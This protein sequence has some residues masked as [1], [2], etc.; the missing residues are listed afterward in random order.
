MPTTTDSTTVLVTV[1]KTSGRSQAFPLDT[2]STLTTIREFLTHQ[3][4]MSLNDSFLVDS[5]TTV[6]R[7]QESAVKLADVLKERVLLIGVASD[8]SP[9][10]TDDGVARYNLLNDDQKQAIFDNIQVFRGLAFG[11]NTFGKTFKDIYSWA[12][13][14]TPAAN[15]PRVITE[16]VSRYAFNKATSEIKNYSS[17]TSSVN[18]STP[19]ASGE[20]EFKT[21]KSKTTSTSNVTE[22]LMTKYIVRKVDLK[23]DTQRLVVN[24]AFLA[25]VRTALKDNEKTADGYHNLIAVLDEYGYYVPVE[26]TL[27]GAIIGT[28]QTTISEFSQAESEKKEFNS[29]FKA[30]FEGIGGG[31]AY[32][33]ASGTDK[34]TSTSSKYQNIV[35][36]GVGGD[37]G[38]EKDYPKWAESLKP[39][40][41]WNLA[42]VS[43]FMPSLLL[44]TTDDEGRR[45]L[46]TAITLIERFGSS[47]N[48][49]HLTP[50][51]N[52]HAYNTTM[53][54]AVNPFA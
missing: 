39:A 27:G 10:A 54:I 33:T 45:L 19:Y 42:D 40:I 43:K 17:D 34:A 4:M 29:S 21:E 12:P 9:I 13:G 36:L 25:A 15:M 26:Y 30:Q 11:T 44:L 3:R 8:T 48:T 1:K 37:P 31:A 52:M 5:T 35:T 14:Y 28:D 49:A 2:T 16:L 41:K 47:G 53:Q 32:K 18:F 51:I 6:N 24:P 46:G 7:D 23:V 50:F 38:L 22:F 20:S